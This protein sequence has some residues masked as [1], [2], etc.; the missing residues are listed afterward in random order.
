[1]QQLKSLHMS[2]WVAPTDSTVPCHVARFIYIRY[3]QF[4]PPPPPPT[5]TTHKTSNLP[6]KIVEGWAVGGLMKI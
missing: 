1:M 2:V 5:S 6:T 4:N 3:F